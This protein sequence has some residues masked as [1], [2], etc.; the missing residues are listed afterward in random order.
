MD[1]NFFHNW[2]NPENTF[3]VLLILMTFIWTSGRIFARLKLPSV[4]G[5][6]IAG[7]IIGPTVLGIIHETETIKV[8]AELGVFFIMFHAGLDTNPKELF[9]SSKASIIIACGGVITLCLFGFFLMQFLG[10]SL[11]TSIFMGTILSVTS[12]PVIT[13]VLSD[14]KLQNT[15]LGHTVLGATIVDDIIVFILLSIVIAMAETGNLEI[16]TMLFI[17]FKILIFFTGTLFLGLKVI[18]KFTHILNKTGTKGFTF[19]LI[20]ALVFGLFAERIGLHAILGA[21]IGGVFV[22]QETEHFHTFHKI[23]DRFF[24]IAHSFLG[25]IFFASVGMAMS[26]SIFYE[27]PLLIFLLFA[28]IIIGQWIGTGGTAYIVENFTFKEASTVAVSMSGRGV[29]EII[30]ATIGYNTWII[31]DGSP[32]RLL[33]QELFSA[34]VAVSI[35]ITFLMPFALKWLTHKTNKKNTHKSSYKQYS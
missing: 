6:I 29:M 23:E 9:R 12:F 13:R 28:T 7:I 19:A 8:L 32:V 15:K 35:L 3:E 24:G 21:Y 22:R 16:Q 4:L 5:E 14:L 26:F 25:P 18:P 33:S 10:Y 20:I 27:N 11:I 31:E 1:L 17:F 2:V 30:I 34:T